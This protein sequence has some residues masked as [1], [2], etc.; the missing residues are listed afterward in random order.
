M[1]QREVAEILE[2]TEDTI[3]NWE[4]NRGEPQIHYYPKIIQFLGYVP[5]DIDTS[6][7]AGRMILYRHLKGIRQE[8]LALELGIDASSVCRY[9]GGHM[10]Y[11]KIVGKIDEHLVAYLKKDVYK[12]FI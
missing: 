11:K 4:N 2:V 10:P 8:E 3:T 12:R 6:T 9:E 1:L 7:L 5:L